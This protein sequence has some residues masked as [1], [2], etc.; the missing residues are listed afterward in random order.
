MRDSIVTPEEEAVLIDLRK[1]YN[2]TD[3]EHIL[4]LLK[5]GMFHDL[6]LFFCMGVCN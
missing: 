2:I 5:A 3:N 1:Q 6:T 4:C